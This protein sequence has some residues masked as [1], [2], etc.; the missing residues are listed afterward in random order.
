VTVTLTL[1][2]QFVQ[3]EG[4]DLKTTRA[5]DKACSYYVAGYYFT[6]AYKRKVWDGKE[7]LF[8][9]SKKHGDRAPAGMAEDIVRLLKQRRVKYWVKFDTVLK[10]DKVKLAWNPAVKLRG[11]QREAVKAMLGKPVPGRGVLKMPIRSGKT[12]T[13]AKI[14]QQIGRPT[15]FVVP[16]KSL[17]HQTVKSLSECL[18]DTEIGMVGDGHFD[19]QFVTVAT[20]QTLAGMAPKRAT[21]K[22]KAREADP[23]YLQSSGTYTT[24]NSDIANDVNTH[25]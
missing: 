4:V 21:P 23:R 6:P 19:P 24:S 1:G 13:V 16:S 20:I 25:S 18:P 15:L 17:L 11:Y 8:K 2:N 22:Q 5:I 10:H 14:I 3:V 7:H 9:S 12:K